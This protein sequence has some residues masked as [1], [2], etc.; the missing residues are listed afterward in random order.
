[1]DYEYNDEAFDQWLKDWFWWQRM[2]PR[3]I[4]A[5]E[6]AYRKR[7]TAPIHENHSQNEDKHSS[8]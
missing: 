3:L 8:E 6:D 5:V 2:R 7:L 4:A 1:M